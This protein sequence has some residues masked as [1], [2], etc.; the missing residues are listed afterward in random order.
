MV[1]VGLGTICGFRHQLG[2]L[3]CIFHGSGLVGGAPVLRGSLRS[4]SRAV[5]CSLGHAQESTGDLKKC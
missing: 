1:H 5:F 2:V 3:E 4:L